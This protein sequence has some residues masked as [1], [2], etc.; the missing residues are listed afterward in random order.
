LRHGRLQEPCRNRRSYRE[1]E[2]RARL[3]RKK[4]RVSAL[5]FHHKNA[6]DFFATRRAGPQARDAADERPTTRFFLKNVGGAARI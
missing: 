2:S 5:P 6:G 1:P 4:Q 3:V